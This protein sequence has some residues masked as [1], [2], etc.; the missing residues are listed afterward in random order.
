MLDS[1]RIWI[2]D[3]REKPGHYDFHYKSVW[4]FIRD[5]NQTYTRP[6]ADN[7]IS[8]II[9]LDHDSG[10]YERYGGDYINILKWLEYFDSDYVKKTCVFYFH[11][12]NPVG[13][14]NM[15]NI[16]ERNGWKYIR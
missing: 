13:R 8:Y 6:K 14:Y 1:I 9:D 7:D 12:S 15:I 4:D 11:T 16:C 3:V 5:F 10:D 2:D